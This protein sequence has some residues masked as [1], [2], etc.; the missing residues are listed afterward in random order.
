MEHTLKKIINSEINHEPFS[1]LVI[2]DFIDPSL[3]NE[4]L[5]NLPDKDKLPPFTG[6]DGRFGEK[7]EIIKNNNPSFEK[8]YN[9][10]HSNEIKNEFLKKFEKEIKLRNEKNHDCVLNTIYTYDTSSY[11][12]APHRDM[13]EKLITFLY[14]FH[15][16]GNGTNL[17]N[18]DETF[19]KMV[20]FKNNRAVLFVPYKNTWHGVSQF[21]N[22]SRTTIQSFYKLK[23]LAK[24]NWESSSKNQV[25]K[26]NRTNIKK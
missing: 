10:F 18:N 26:K 1:H 16:N 15:G 17:Y 24:R 23:F 25:Y 13:A 14:Y 3:Y 2:D 11:E 9:V 5:N 19:N 20:E 22:S 8:L 6:F 12:I 4:C 21:D 7:L